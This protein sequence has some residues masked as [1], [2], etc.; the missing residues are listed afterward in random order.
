MSEEFKP[1]VHPIEPIKAIVPGINIPDKLLRTCQEKS[2]DERQGGGWGV[3]SRGIEE[4]NGEFQPILPMPI[5]EILSER[6][7]KGEPSAVLDVMGFGTIL[8]QLRDKGIPFSHGYSLSLGH[9]TNMWY[10]QLDQ[11]RAQEKN[12]FHLTGNILDQELWKTLFTEMKE[13]QT[14]KFGLVIWAPAGGLSSEYITDSLEVYNQL[15]QNIWS[16]TSVTNGTILAEIPPWVTTNH[17]QEF[18]T[19][20]EL[21][22]KSDTGIKRHPFVNFLKH[23]RSNG[24]VMVLDKTP[25]RKNLPLI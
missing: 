19:W 16:I 9:W 6:C 12:I 21:L 4:F 13:K 23:P 8:Y 10:H 11:K 25:L 5:T 14:G 7:Q 22:A 24:G 3:M 20:L 17:N 15:L 1:W 18:H 2:L